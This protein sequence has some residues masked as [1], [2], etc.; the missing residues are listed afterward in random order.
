MTINDIKNSDGAGCI[1]CKIIN[2]EIP[3]SIIYEDE[4]FMCFLNINPAVKGHSLLIPKEHHVWIQDIPDEL[5]AK[6]FIVTKKIINSMII[7][8]DCNHIE[9]IIDGIKIPHFH[10]HLIPRWINDGLPEFETIKYESDEEKQEFV[11]KIK[12]AL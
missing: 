7:G 2:K 11:S 5:L 8:L 12:N 3:S 6:S 10:I 1:F 9:I 4:K